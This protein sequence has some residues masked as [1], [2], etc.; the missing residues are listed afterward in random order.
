MKRGKAF[1]SGGVGGA[2]SSRCLKQL[3]ALWPKSK[4]EHQGE[5]LKSHS[6]SN[7][8][9]FMFLGEGSPSPGPGKGS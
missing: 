9:E 3:Q 2:E 5:T 8:V 7:R 1:A 4:S 6:K